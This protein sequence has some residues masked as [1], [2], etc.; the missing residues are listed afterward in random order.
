MATCSVTGTIVDS[1]AVAVSGVAIRFRV[2]KPLL[3][4]SS[5]LVVPT[6]VSTTTASNG[7]WSISLDQGISGIMSIDFPASTTASTLRSSYSI[8]VPSQTSATFASLMPSEV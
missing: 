5:N 4:A 8:T 6:E 7:S 3:D 2:V 1:S